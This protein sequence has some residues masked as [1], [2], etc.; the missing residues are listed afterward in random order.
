MGNLLFVPRVQ[1]F[2]E[3]LIF[4]LIRVYLWKETT[5]SAGIDNINDP[6]KKIIDMANMC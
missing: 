2:K 5:G 3:C 6:K 4:H 1:S